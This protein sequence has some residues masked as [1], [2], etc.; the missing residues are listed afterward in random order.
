MICSTSESIDVLSTAA[1]GA[2]FEVA[3][4]KYA[5]AAAVWLQCH[6][7]RHWAATEE[8]GFLPVAGSGFAMML[9]AIQVGPGVNI[10]FD[11]T[12]VSVSGGSVV[13]A[14]PLVLD[15]LV[16]DPDCDR[17]VLDAVAGVGLLVGMVMTLP[18]RLDLTASLALSVD[19]ERA[20]LAISGQSDPG[21]AV[22]SYGGRSL[23]LTGP[24]LTGG[25]GA[26][27]GD[28]SVDIEERHWELAS[29][30]ALAT[31]VPSSEESRLRGAGAGLTDND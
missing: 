29:A 8:G 18:D 15:A 31:H 9:E 1:R 28:Y 19:G 27:V 3:A 22:F 20:Q 10:G 11:A 12:T 21:S 30:L 14:G 16:G 5:A 7:E 2:G 24:V 13:D 23:T 17:V 6:G 26:T 4:S 25:S